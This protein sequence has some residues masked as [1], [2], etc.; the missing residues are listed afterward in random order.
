M[1][2]QYFNVVEKPHFV[3]SSG[4]IVFFENHNGTNLTEFVEFIPRL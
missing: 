3:F 2:A 4:G 1:P